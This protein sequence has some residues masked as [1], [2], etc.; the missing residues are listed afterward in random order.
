L[1]YLKKDKNIVVSVGHH[2]RLISMFSG[3]VS[4]FLSIYTHQVGKRIYIKDKNNKNKFIGY[5]FVT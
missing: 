4:T 5:I 1:H 2:L 3:W